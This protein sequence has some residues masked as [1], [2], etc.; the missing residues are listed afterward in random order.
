MDRF[1]TCTSLLYYNF[2]MWP[3]NILSS[4]CHVN[5][6][7]CLISCLS[8]SCPPTWS[9]FNSSCFR[10]YFSQ[11]KILS[12]TE[13]Q[14]RT[15]R[16][17]IVLLVI[18]YK[19]LISRSIVA[20][21]RPGA[22]CPVRTASQRSTSSWSSGSLKAG[23]GTRRASTS[24]GRSLRYLNIFWK[25]FEKFKIKGELIW[26]DGSPTDYL[27]WS[28]EART[29]KGCIAVFSNLLFRQTRKNFR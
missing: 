18:H 10:G 5:D 15:I 6:P 7:Y 27:L 16:E 3:Q 1:K 11:D 19:T 2:S 24:E 20:W 14:V 9:A 4:V 8:A 22:S 29:E 23:S 26:S 12:Y 17:N 25:F 21:R 28:E 13:A